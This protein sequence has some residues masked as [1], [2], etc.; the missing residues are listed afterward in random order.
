MVNDANAIRMGGMSIES[1]PK[2]LTSENWIEWDRSIH[3]YL[4]FNSLD[5]AMTEELTGASTSPQRAVMLKAST[6]LKHT[7]G[8]TAYGLVKD[9]ANVS[10]IFDKLKK[11]GREFLSL[12][13][14]SFK[15]IDAYADEFRRYIRDL[16]THKITLPEPFLIL[17][18]KMGFSSALQ[19]FL[20]I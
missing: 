10:E 18:F 15:D 17:M 3:D 20:A 13:L 2:L 19:P 4:I 9:L 1:V 7:C 12:K 8:H 6:A 5:T 16:T 11:L 14:E